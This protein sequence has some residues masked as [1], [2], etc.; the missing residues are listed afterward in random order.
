[1]KQINQ[2]LHQFLQKRFKTFRQKLIFSFLVLSIVPILLIGAASYWMTSAI[3]K[4]KI[5]DSVDYT[6]N[7]LNETFSNRFDQIENTSNVIQ[8]YLYSL[9]LQPSYSVS[10]Q[11]DKYSEVKNNI[12]NLTNSFQFF[13]IS[14]Y[15]KSSN[16]F[17]NEGITFHRLEEA[18][19]R[20][21]DPALA[22]Q[23]ASNLHWGRFE[24]IR[25]PIV[26]DSTGEA[27]V[28]S[29]FKSFK[30]INQEEAEY[31]F[32][33]DIK[34]S[35][36]SELLSNSNKDSSLV[37]YVVDEKGRVIA[38]SKES[39]G[40][41]LDKKM[42]EQIKQS[43]RQP[44]AMIDKTLVIHQN[45]ETGWFVVTEIP[46]SYISKNTGVLVNI[47]L[48]AVIFVLIAAVLFSLF[49]SNNLSAKVR[50]M[51]KEMG[52]FSISRPYEK[53]NELQ[54]LVPIKKENRDEF[55]ELA[56][57]FN[58]MIKKTNDSFDQ[59]LHFKLQEEKLRYQLEQS[60]INPHFL[61]NILESIKTCLMTGRVE[62]ANEMLTRLARF[63]RLLLKKG[64]DLILIE[65]ELQITALYLEIEKLNRQNSFTWVIEAEEGIDQFLIPKFTLQPI[66]E[67]CIHH[68]LSGQAQPMH[69][70]L[71]LYFKEDEIVIRIQDTG[72][73]INE[74]MLQ[75][76]NETLSAKK[77]NAS[78][79]YGT[80]NVN[81]RLSMYS[82]AE[83][84][85]IYEQSTEGGTVAVIR[86]SQM[87]SDDERFD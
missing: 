68:G 80:S 2:L 82:E 47:I 69:V 75:S 58:T 54:L 16:L 45:K 38:H 33:V 74:Q 3:A 6:N 55:D 44:V 72:R 34:E 52:S 26:V 28:I 40:R 46:E 57:V 4:D 5:L 63:Y 84:P 10:S 13:H 86:F 27:T 77:P 9:L 49:I 41:V 19:E 59:L 7:Q 85:L 87:I 39:A 15:V 73:G 29:A 37:S 66:V 48:L 22:E 30:P 42:M 65:D 14:V 35:E 64:D 20:G 62:V 79:F 83:Q 53:V 1:M 18:K 51:S 36:L 50:S 81:L 76:L 43:N 67:N 24:G 11:L 60:K 71:S 61:Y 12:A 31:I 25:F 8:Y 70:L 56:I 78:R 17:S 21:I 32:F 23:Y